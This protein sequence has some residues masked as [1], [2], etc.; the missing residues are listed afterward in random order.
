M[1]LF[2]TLGLCIV[3]AAGNGGG[4]DPVTKQRPTHKL[5]VRIKPT[6]SVRGLDIRIGDF[7]EILP[8]GREALELGKVEF[9]R[10]PTQ[11]HARTIGRTELIQAIAGA[12]HDLSTLKF[13]G[14][15]ESSVQ[16]IVVDVP[17]SEVLES[18]RTALQALLVVE[19]GDIEIEAPKNLRAVQAPPGRRSQEIVARVR[20]GKTGPT[21]AIVDIEIE[22]D[23]EAWKRVP[24]TFKLTRFQHVLRTVGPVR[25]GS[26]LGP[27]NLEL[28]R[29]PV[30]QQTNLLLNDF[31]QVDG[32]VAAHDLKADRLVMLADTAPPAA[33]HKG[34][35]VTVVI[36]SGR[37]KVTARAMANHDAPIAGRITLTNVTSKKQLVGVVAAPGLVVLH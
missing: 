17:S 33:V 3:F 18:A 20:G 16:A 1:N 29:Q 24:V 8:S 19:G 12:G 5:E 37:V 26:E 21:S 30:A 2:A 6:A 25:A 36:D 14:A 15:T 28:V 32:L 4:D 7:C 35:I 31:A 27:Q 23:G 9:G 13:E 34:E 10:S 11:G 22:V